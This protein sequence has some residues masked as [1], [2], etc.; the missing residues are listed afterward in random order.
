MKSIRL[1]TDADDEVVETVGFYETRRNGLGSAFLVEFERSLQLIQQHPESGRPLES[2]FR[3]MLTNR[4]PFTII[5]V[6]RE[7]EFLV[8]AVAHTSRKP[9]YWKNRLLES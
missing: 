9:G 7:Q 4:F 8:I 1:L 2:R 5:Y 3:Q 6:E